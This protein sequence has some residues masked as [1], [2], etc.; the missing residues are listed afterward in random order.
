MFHLLSFLGL[1]PFSPWFLMLSRHCLGNYKTWQFSMAD[2]LTATIIFL[3]DLNEAYK[4]I[5]CIQN[6]GLNLDDSFIYKF[7]KITCCCNVFTVKLVKLAMIRQ[8]GA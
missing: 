1:G 6:T 2:G 8:K 5:I 3:A 4:S 7:K